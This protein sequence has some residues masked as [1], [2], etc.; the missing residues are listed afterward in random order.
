MQYHILKQDES[1]VCYHPVF[2]RILISYLLP[3]LLASVILNMPKILNILG[4]FE[5]MPFEYDIYVIKVFIY[6]HIHSGG[7]VLFL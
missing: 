1:S 5:L 4:V 7:S 6:F 2:G 3:V